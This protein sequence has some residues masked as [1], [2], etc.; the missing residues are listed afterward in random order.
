MT[1]P[2]AERMVGG[3]RCWPCTIAN[4][5]VALVVAGIPLYGALG[6]GDAVVVGVTGVWAVA[7]LGFTLYRLLS[8][9][10]LPGAERA[11]TAT[12]L[13]DRIGPGRHEAEPPPDSEEDG[14]DRGGSPGS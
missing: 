10:Y 7:V 4:G 13:H 6:N 1:G 5:L 9:G 14:D 3:D 12:G 2:E 11:A 8:R